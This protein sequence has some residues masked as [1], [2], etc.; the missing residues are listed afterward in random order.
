[1]SLNFNNVA[2]FD[3][4]GH[5]P[6]FFIFS[7]CV[8]VNSSTKSVI[9]QCNTI[10]KLERGGPKMFQR[11][12]FGIA[13]MAFSAW[14]D[15]DE[16][17]TKA[18]HQRG[19]IEEKTKVHRLSST[20]RAVYDAFTYVNRLPE[21]AEKGESAEDVA[22]RIFGRLANQE[23]R[24]L[25]KL[26]AGMDRDSYLAFK[27]FFRYE[28]DAAVGNCAACHTPTEFTDSKAHVVTKGGSPTVTPSLRNLKKRKIDIPKAI[29]AK[30]TASRQKRS[31]DVDEIDDAYAR[32]NISKKDVPGLVAFL[33]LLNDVPDSEFR[34][35]IL[36]AK[37]LDTSED[38]K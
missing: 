34:S 4:G 9:G 21:G 35:L 32:M 26:P 19:S 38:I 8:C 20:K 7:T 25:L 37:L 6:N 1:M 11:L 29:M 31:H 12:L 15:E 2:Q 13:L 3:A 16:D 33:N 36:K 18:H 28:G 14:A 27:T 22:G 30:I 5:D 24:I 10:L 17:A 23:G